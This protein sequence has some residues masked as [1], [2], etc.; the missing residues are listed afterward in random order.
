VA[1][2]RTLARR[3]V[4]AFGEPVDTP[5][6]DLNRLFPSAERI[7]AADPD[8]LGRLGI[9]RQRVGALQALA[10]AVAE[11]RIVLQPAAPLQP[12]LQALLALPGIG[13]WT[14]Q[15][16]AM[17]VLAWPDAF[18]ASDI[19]VLKALGT[20]DVPLAEARAEAW[21]PW[22]AYAVMALW[23]SLEDNTP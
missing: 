11:G 10:Q 5:F 3:L 8:Q 9:V 6:P 19:G 12:T 21:R 18:A 7:A 16:I 23:H 22:R 13:E 15:M 2:A 20:R 4:E 1:A 14:A 17:R